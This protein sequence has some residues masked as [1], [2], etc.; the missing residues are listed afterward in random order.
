MSEGVRRAAS[1]IETHARLP[2]WPW[3]KKKS[4]K[5]MKGPPVWGLHFSHFFVFL[6]VVFDPHLQKESGL[7]F[8]VPLIN[9][10]TSGQEESGIPGVSKGCC[11]E[12]VKYLRA[13]KKH[14]FVTPGTSFS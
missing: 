14:S 2:T 7:A 3:V 11:L 9:L 10:S 8:S 1:R 5:K 6:S 4:P 13:S 12:V